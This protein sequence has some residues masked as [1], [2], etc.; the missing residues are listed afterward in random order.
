MKLA[1][2]LKFSE[3]ILRDLI[4]IGRDKKKKA[5]IF[6]ERI[7]EEIR[8]IEP[9]EVQKD[10][11]IP[12][13]ENQT[14]YYRDE[15]N[16]IYIGYNSLNESFVIVCYSISYNQYLLK[17]LRYKDKIKKVDIDYTL[18]KITEFLLLIKSKKINSM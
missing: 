14:I 16:N 4:K 18:N 6:N 5:I 17:G 7:Y 11:I 9:K 2:E 15:E 10:N 1:K 3:D 13:K 12:F 8:K